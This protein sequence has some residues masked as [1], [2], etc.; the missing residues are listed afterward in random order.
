[1]ITS[2]DFLTVEDVLATH[3]DQVDRHGGSHG[4]RDMNLLQ[5]AVAAA[6]S[7]AGGL[8]FHA[9]VFEMAA[10]YLFHIARNHPFADGNKRTAAL[11]A[12]VF[13]EINGIALAATNP[14]YERLVLTV[15]TGKAAKSDAAVF[16][17]RHSKRR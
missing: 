5:S 7:G 14:A 11:A 9:D 2:P 3:Q 16:L 13:L 1:V 10:A 4:V 17:R 6:Q 15:A 8:Y 12:F